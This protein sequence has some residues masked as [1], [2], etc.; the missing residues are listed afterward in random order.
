MIS[1]NIKQSTTQMSKPRDGEEPTNAKGDNDQTATEEFGVTQ[2]MENVATE[3][4]QQKSLRSQKSIERNDKSME[5]ESD[6]DIIKPE[7]SGG[8]MEVRVIARIHS[9]SAPGLKC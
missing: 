2:G 4:P 7:E 5:V 8:F 9:S 3:Q 1:Q 6:Q